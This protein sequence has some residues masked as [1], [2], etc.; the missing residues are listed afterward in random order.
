M[1]LREFDSWA[2]HT[3]RFPLYSRCLCGEFLL[4]SDLQTPFAAV[5]D[6]FRKKVFFF[7][8]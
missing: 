2:I 4:Q 7:L 3:F 5:T 1:V 8:Q 6:R